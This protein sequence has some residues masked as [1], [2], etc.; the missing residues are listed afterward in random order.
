MKIIAGK[1]YG[2]VPGMQIVDP[3]ATDLI[4]VGTLAIGVKATLDEL[5][6]TIHSHPAVTETIRE[7]ALDAENHTFMLF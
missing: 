3:H 5:I 7:A 2:E 6:S 4:A 1:Q